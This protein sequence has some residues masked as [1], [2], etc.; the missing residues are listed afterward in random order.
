M[1]FTTFDESTDIS[2]TAQLEVTE[3]MLFND[4]IIK[5]LLKYCQ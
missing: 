3:K 4:I 2:E 1:I 5:D